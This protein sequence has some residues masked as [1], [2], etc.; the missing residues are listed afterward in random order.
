MN[1]HLPGWPIFPAGDGIAQFLYPQHSFA[2]WGDVVPLPPDE[3]PAITVEKVV[4]EL[5]K[6]KVESEADAVKKAVEIAEATVRFEW[7]KKNIGESIDSEMK[8][9]LKQHMELIEK[10]NLSPD[11][12]ASSRMDLVRAWRTKWPDEA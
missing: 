11:R 4:G 3:L 9:L 5:S 6:P 12:L 2:R 1:N 8:T 7:V 10:A